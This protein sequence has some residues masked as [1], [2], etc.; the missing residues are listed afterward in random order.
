MRTVVTTMW[1]NIK[2]ELKTCLAQNSQ[3]RYISGPVPLKNMQ[4]LFLFIISVYRMYICFSVKFAS[5]TGLDQ[6]DYVIRLIIEYAY[7]FP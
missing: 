3:V 1:F 5:F 4:N 2:P 6:F 7:L